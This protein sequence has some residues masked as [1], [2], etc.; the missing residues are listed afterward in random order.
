MSEFLDVMNRSTERY[1]NINVKCNGN[2]MLIYKDNWE[3][4]LT[5]FQENILYDKIEQYMNELLDNNR[6]RQGQLLL[7][8][9]TV[10]IEDN[11]D[12]TYSI[13]FKFTKR[14]HHIDYFRLELSCFITEYYKNCKKII[15]SPHKKN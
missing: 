7:K 6:Y 10:K 13:M 5:N 8:T 2:K 1:L 14:Y 11:V 12:Y 9:E 4:Y 3:G 15:A